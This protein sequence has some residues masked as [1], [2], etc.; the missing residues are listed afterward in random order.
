MRGHRLAD[1]LEDNGG[2]DGGQNDYY[3]DAMDSQLLTSRGK[4]VRIRLHNSGPVPYCKACQHP[5]VPWSHDGELCDGWQQTPSSR[6]L[7]LCRHIFSPFGIGVT[8]LCDAQ[9][10][11]DLL[12]TY[13]GGPYKSRGGSIKRTRYVQEEEEEEDEENEEGQVSNFS[14][15][16]GSISCL[17]AHHAAPVCKLAHIRPI[18]WYAEGHRFWSGTLVTSSGGW[19]AGSANADAKAH[20]QSGGLPESACRG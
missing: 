14:L 16:Y 9:V 6:Q 2:N 17:C 3:D 8:Y 5:L 12:D 19:A 1:A 18:C 10:N 13:P 20:S 15:F 4:E 11:Y 7:A